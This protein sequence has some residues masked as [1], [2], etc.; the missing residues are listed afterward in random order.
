[1]FTKAFEPLAS[2]GIQVIAVDTPGYG[3]SDAPK[4]QP[5]IHDYSLCVLDPIEFLK[6]EKISLLGHHTGACIVAELSVIASDRVDKLI[7]NGPP[8]LTKKRRTI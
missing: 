1:M 7:L 5:N 4:T 3:Q 2:S 6:L 8:V